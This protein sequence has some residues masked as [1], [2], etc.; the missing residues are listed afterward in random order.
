MTMQIICCDHERIVSTSNDNEE[1]SSD[2][3]MTERDIADLQMADLKMARERFHRTIIQ[4]DARKVVALLKRPSFPEDTQIDG[5]NESSAK[6]IA[7]WQLQE[8]EQVEEENKEEE[9]EQE[10]EEEGKCHHEDTAVPELR[11]FQDI[12]ASQMEE[13]GDAGRLLSM[14]YREKRY[15]RVEELKRQSKSD[16]EEEEEEKEDEEEMEDKNEGKE[17][18]SKKKDKDEEDDEDEDEEGEREDDNNDDEKDEKDAK[19]WH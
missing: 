1:K 15:E 18:E 4:R 12:I 19:Q 16:T 5:E 14:R 7:I 8:E 2:D 10:E 9:N 17:E 11:Y 3:I 6:K 13:L